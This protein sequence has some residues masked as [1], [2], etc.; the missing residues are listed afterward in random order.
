MNRKV[1][2]LRGS[3]HPAISWVEGRGPGGKRRQG[4]PN[5]RKGEEGPQPTCLDSHPSAAG[6]SFPTAH[7]SP[8]RQVS[9][10]AEWLGWGSPQLRSR[11]RR[12]ASPNCCPRPL[13]RPRPSSSALPGALRFAL[14]PP[15]PAP[16]ERPRVERSAVVDSPASDNAKRR[17]ASFLMP[18]AHRLPHPLPR[19]RAS[20]PRVAAPFHHQ[21]A[22][23]R[24]G[25]TA[26]Q[27]HGHRENVPADTTCSASGD[28]P[29]SPLSPQ[30]SMDRSCANG[31]DR[32]K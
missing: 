8:R 5:L 26:P 27:A 4:V 1:M 14:V 30:G 17:P 13:P 3:R 16:G 11:S 7:Q 22:A 28:A 29:R 21:A 24:S 15:G 10:R 31:N 20:S 18:S 19:R 12:H 2:R 32:R 6:A 9:D 25:C 23:L